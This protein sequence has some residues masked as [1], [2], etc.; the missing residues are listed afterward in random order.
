[1][2]VLRKL[3][4]LA[5]VDLRL[6]GSEGA[7]YATLAAVQSLAHCSRLV[8]AR[9]LGWERAPGSVPRHCTCRPARPLALSASY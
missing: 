9:V 5:H 6:S 3:P 7:A 4:R 8:R 1:M 2:E